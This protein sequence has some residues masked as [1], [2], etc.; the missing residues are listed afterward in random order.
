MYKD[1]LS[2]EELDELNQQK[3]PAENQ[4]HLV[5]C[6]QCKSLLEKFKAVSA[7]LDKLASVPIGADNAMN[8]PEERIWFEV[9]AGT[10]PE[11]E[12]LQHIQHAAECSSCGRKLKIATRMFEEQLSPEEK[13]TLAQLPSAEAKGQRKLAERLG[14]TAATNVRVVADKRKRSFWKPLSFSLAGAAVAIAAVLVFVSVNR[15]DSPADVAKLLAQAYTEN[16]TIE[17]RIPGAKHAEI[18]QQ[19]SGD[20]GSLLNTP[21]AARK[22][23]DRISA[24]LKKDP[25]NPDWLILQAQLDLLDWRYKAAMSALNKAGTGSDRIDFLLTRALALNEEGEVEHNPLVQGEAIDLLGRVLQ[26]DPNN[27]TAL[28]NQAIV[29]ETLYMYECASK[30]WQQLLS[31]EKDTGWAAEA[32]EH[33]NRIQ[34]KKTLER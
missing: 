26:K 21:E 3:G 31:I 9:A 6:P 13:E 32:R 23:A 11:T 27:S 2:L 14:G 10:L 7:K 33:L 17:T 22:A 24:G 34:E 29:C 1:H 19:K 25:N 15:H 12:S 28:F 30:D 4:T 16:R 5:A 8:C 18:R 20:T